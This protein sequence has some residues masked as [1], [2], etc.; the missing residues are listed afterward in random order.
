MLSYYN[1]RINIGQHQS[2]NAFN[3]FNGVICFR[4]VNSCKFKKDVL[5]VIR[6]HH[7]RP[8][9]FLYFAATHWKS[10]YQNAGSATPKP[11]QSYAVLSAIQQSPSSQ[12]SPLSAQNQAKNAKNAPPADRG[13]SHRPKERMHHNIP[14]R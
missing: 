4:A 1:D 13:T 6:R 10:Q 7:W 14:H 3:W 5:R 2:T 12:P 8:T 9:S 11:A